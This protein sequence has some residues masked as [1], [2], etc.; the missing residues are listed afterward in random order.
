MSTA[1]LSVTLPPKVS[2]GCNSNN[3][4]HSL[5]TIPFEIGISAYLAITISGSKRLVIACSSSKLLRLLRDL[6]DV[7]VL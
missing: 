2:C 3:N 4:F 7:I 1:T 5:T 6:T